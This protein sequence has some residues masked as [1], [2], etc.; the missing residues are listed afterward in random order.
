[1]TWA[2]NTLRETE[3]SQ[4]HIYGKHILAFACQHC[5]KDT[6]FSRD[7][8]SIRCQLKTFSGIYKFKHHDLKVLFSTLIRCQLSIHQGSFSHLPFLLE[9]MFLEKARLGLGKPLQ[10]ITC[11]GHMENSLNSEPAKIWRTASNHRVFNVLFGIWAK[12]K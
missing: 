5:L 7:R 4:G 1:M 10:T 3:I 12:P 6:L 11:K 2:H 8:F 9:M